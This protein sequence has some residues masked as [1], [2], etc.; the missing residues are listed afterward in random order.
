VCAREC[1]YGRACVS[2]CVFD[3]LAEYSLSLFLSLSLSL[4]RSLSL[5]L[6]LSRSLSLARSLAR[7]LALSLARALSPSLSR[8]RALS[9]TPQ[10]VHGSDDKS[11]DN[12][13]EYGFNRSYAGKNACSYGISKCLFGNLMGTFIGGECLCKRVNLKLA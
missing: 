13:A 2:M 7:S 8:A 6:S 5:A 12:I 3:N 10:A 11:L 4:S 9:H 1:S